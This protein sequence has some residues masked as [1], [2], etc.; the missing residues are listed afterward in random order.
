[1]LVSDSLWLFPQFS[2]ALF[3][4]QSR[5][6]NFSCCIKFVGQLENN[7]IRRKYDDP[8][9][10]RFNPHWFLQ[11]QIL[12]ETVLGSKGVTASVKELI[13]KNLMIDTRLISM[14]YPT[15]RL[16]TGCKCQ[17]RRYNYKRSS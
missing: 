8:Y 14:C 1:M 4:D 7:D 6:Y 15:L 13:L 2:N 9:M 10:F 12:L 17:R 5:G 3:T 16:S 11:Q